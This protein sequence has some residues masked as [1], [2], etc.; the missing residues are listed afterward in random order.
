LITKYAVTTPGW[1]YRGRKGP[2]LPGNRE[3]GRRDRGV[4][5]AAERP[6][7]LLTGSWKTHQM[8]SP[9][10]RTVKAIETSELMRLDDEARAYGFNRH[11]GPGWLATNAAPSAIHYLHPVVVHAAGRRPEFSPHWR[12]TLLL[13]LRDDQEV[14][15]LLDVWPQTF[16]QL[17][18]TLDAE[19]KSTISQRLLQGNLPTQAQW[20]ASHAGDDSE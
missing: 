17:P 3:P 16:E 2:Q 18:E 10:P 12:C 8:S 5:I 14:F 4:S 7:H 13:T 6:D 20:V 1:A 11:H 9:V 15:S 19:T